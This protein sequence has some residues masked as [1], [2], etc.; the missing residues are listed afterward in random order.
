MDINHRLSFLLEGN[1]LL[2]L[3]LVSAM[4]FVKVWPTRGGDSGNR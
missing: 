4:K 1:L 3:S 2:C